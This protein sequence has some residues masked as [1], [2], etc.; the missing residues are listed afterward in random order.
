MDNRIQYW[1]NN[2]KQG[3]IIM[4]DVFTNT[5]AR[6]ELKTMLSEM[7]RA[8]QRMDDEREHLK[9]IAKAAEEKFNIKTKIVRKLAST[10]YK[11]NYADWQQENEHFESLY[12]T[13][14]QAKSSENAQ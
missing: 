13:L 10:M 9:D 14:V 5:V 3:D 8:M 1:H 2:Y 7:T 6:Q 4:S 12:E 11:H